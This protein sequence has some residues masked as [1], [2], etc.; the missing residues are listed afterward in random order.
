MGHYQKQ[1]EQETTTA[2]FTP[3]A[4]A[5]SWLWSRTALFGSDSPILVVLVWSAR[6]KHEQGQII[7]L[8]RK[9]SCIR[10][11]KR[12]SVCSLEL[13]AQ[14][15]SKQIPRLRTANP[16]LWGKQKIA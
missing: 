11:T 2:F 7:S 12:S 4:A 14:I 13:C 5:N 1:K 8:L 9:Y 15:I 3:S 16:E 10:R 6:V